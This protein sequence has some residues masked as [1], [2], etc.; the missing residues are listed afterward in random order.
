MAAFDRAFRR[1]AALVLLLLGLCAF[2][3]GARAWDQ[4]SR[5]VLSFLRTCIYYGL[6]LFWGASVRRRILQ[7]SLRRNLSACSG[8]LVL[9]LS[10]RSCKYYLFSA[11]P[12][13]RRLLWYGFYLPIVLLP[14][15]TLFIAVSIGRADE[16]RLPRPLKLLFLPAAA[17][18]ALFLTNDLHHL[19]FVFPQGALLGEKRYAYGP[20]YFAAA[21]W[22]VG[23]GLLA[24]GLLAAKS[25][26]PGSRRFLW[27]PFA[28]FGLGPL[29]CTLYNL[30]VPFVMQAFGDLS[31]TLGLIVVLVL[32]SC[33]QCG[34][35]RSNTRYGELFRLSSVAAQLADGAYRVQYSSAAAKPV[36]EALLRQTEQGPVELDGN[37]RLF[38]VP[39]TGGRAFWQEDVS[40]QNRLLGQIAEA[41]EALSGENALLRAELELRENRARIDARS[42]LYDRMSRQTEPQLR[43]L[44]ALLSGPAPDLEK[45]RRACVPGAYVKRRS[46]LL[47]LGEDSKTLPAQELAFCLRESAEALAGLVPACFVN[48]R[49]EGSLPA[50][51]LLAFYDLFEQLL[52]TLLETLAALLVTLKASGGGAELRLQFSCPAGPETLPPLPA[53]RQFAACGGVCRTEAEDGTLLVTLSLPGKE[54]AT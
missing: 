3:H 11:L 40:E 17:L 50:E 19:A 29:Y 21:A 15:F 44:E 27:P 28:A 8:L 30:R 16:Y 25:R 22:V 26:V 24:L 14:L 38:G 12:A 41:S 33:I 45:L 51:S 48:R 31:V 49:C 34:L 43:A 13:G 32:E 35:I 39:I 18:I 4:W 52:E 10:L 20:V 5:V 23:L 9:W 7:P 47:L 2:L 54:A 53:R 1:R 37:T 46:N 36:S 6:F 42:R